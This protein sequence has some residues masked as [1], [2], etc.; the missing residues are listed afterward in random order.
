MRPARHSAPAATSPRLTHAR[1]FAA[2]C[3]F[4]RLDLLLK[5]RATDDPAGEIVQLMMFHRTN[6]TPQIRA[7]GDIICCS[8]ATVRD[9]PN[10][11]FA[12]ALAWPA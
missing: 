11:F 3:A 6:E 7:V 12:A 5:V 4:P 10:A 1:A 9:D 8:P 2:N